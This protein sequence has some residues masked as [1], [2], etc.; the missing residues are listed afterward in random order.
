MTFLNFVT[1]GLIIS[2]TVQ[3]PY[4]PVGWKKKPQPISLVCCNDLRHT[5]LSK[6]SK[7][8]KSYVTILLKD[9]LTDLLL[10]GS[11]AYNGISSELIITESILFIYKPEHFKAL[12][13]FSTT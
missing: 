10:Y 4:V 7:I 6:I 13:A 3:V 5:F 9:H 12:E 1:I 11:K 8:I 2:S